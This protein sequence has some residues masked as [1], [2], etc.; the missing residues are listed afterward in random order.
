MPGK[1]KKIMGNKHEILKVEKIASGEWLHLD[2]IFFADPLGRNGVWEAAGR[3]RA[4]GA[5]A[6]AAI[7]KP[8]NRL[9]LVS[10]FRPP[11]QSE[12]IE[13]PAGLIDRIEE[14]GATALRELKEETGYKGTIVKILS[15]SYS[16]PGLSGETIYIAV[17]EID[18]TLEENRNPKPE[19]DDGEFIETILV[20]LEGLSGYLAEAYGKGFKL[21]S[22]VVSFALG[23]D[24]QRH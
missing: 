23:M 8:S 9:I 15:P 22:K 1:G 14:I 13:F 10:Q 5:V 19:P 18:E 4:K 6:V 16:S 2:R 17:V 12:V 24:L 3:N 21:D 7:M 20:P 11:A